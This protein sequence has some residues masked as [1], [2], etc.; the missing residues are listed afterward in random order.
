MKPKPAPKMIYLSRD[1]IEFIRNAMSLRQLAGKAI[2]VM[3]RMPG[4]IRWVAGPLTSGTM[5]PAKNRERLHRTI[6]HYKVRGVPTFNYL[7]FERRARAILQ[8]EIGR[9]SNLSRKQHLRLQERLRDGFYA[10][11]FASGFV[12]E[13]RIM[14]G[15]D[16]SLNVQWMRGYANA[17]RIPTKDISEDLVSAAQQSQ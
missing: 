17:K 6:L 4:P 3:T 2:E 11:I 10:P 8:W 16:E 15:S 12:G 5:S 9:G 14:P 13:L 1:D 7:P